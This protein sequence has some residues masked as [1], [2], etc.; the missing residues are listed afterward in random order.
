M[1]RITILIAVKDRWLDNE[2]YDQYGQLIRW[3]NPNPTVVWHS[4]CWN[5]EDG[6][7]V[8]AVMDAQTFRTLTGHIIYGGNVEHRGMHKISILWGRFAKLKAY[9]QT[10]S[11]EQSKNA[12]PA[13][14]KRDRLRE[15]KEGR[16]R[17]LMGIKARVRR[18]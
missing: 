18:R 8:M 7:G 13:P 11:V 9:Q 12:K 14:V 10:L 2:E 5:K 16:A 3:A 17:Q 4:G 1:E 15:Y 6:Q